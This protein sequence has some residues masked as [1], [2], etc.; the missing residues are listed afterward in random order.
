MSANHS[1]QPVREWG[2]LR[3]FAN[4][5]HKELRAWWSTRRWWFNAL[6]W[7]GLF[8]GL[9]SVMLF[10]LPSIAELAE[11]PNVAAAGGRLAFGLEMGRTIF[12]ELGT[13][14]MAIGVIV[15]CQDIIL[16]EKL[17]GLTEWL[18]S[19]PVARRA[20]ILAKLAANGLSIL[21]L[22]IVLP[23]LA[24]YGLLSLRLGTAFPIQPFLGGLGMMVV[25]ALFY[26]T[27]TVMGG[28]L[29]SSRP[30]ILG[31][32]LGILLGG[33]MLIS[34]IKP[35]AFV[36]PWILA[37]TASLVAASE[38]LPGEL[39]WPPLLTTLLWS[40]LFIFITLVKFE[41]TEF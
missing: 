28:T 23:A 17:S 40:L 30:P 8:G 18:L 35:L 32:G 11:D 22:L 13:M 36:T 3:G 1:F 15:L 29:F 27:L 5:Y 16:D 33:N 19:K 41:K 34:I 37:K 39:L 6:L 25:H 26:L 31:L 7:T 4:L 20:Y 10:I 9:V 12:F 14:I 38:P 2:V 21:A 24:T